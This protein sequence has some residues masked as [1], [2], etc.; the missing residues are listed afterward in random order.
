ML[1]I[2]GNT[3]L[4]QSRYISRL[5]YDL[6]TTS[7][8]HFFLYIRRVL[9]KGTTLLLPLTLPNA[10]QFSKFAGRLSSKFVSGKIIIK[11]PTQTGFYL[12]R[13]ATLPSEMF[14]LRSCR[15]SRLCEANCHSAIQNSCWKSI[16]PVMLEL[17]YS[18]MTRYLSWPHRKKKLQNDGL[19]APTITKNK[20]VATTPV[21]EINVQSLMASVGESHVVDITQVTSLILVDARVKISEAYYRNM[22]LLQ[23]FLP[24]IVFFRLQGSFSFFGSAPAHRAC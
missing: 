24:A 8:L 2:Y 12:K 22:M 23:Q 9:E 5:I 6:Y 10:D 19:Y 18:L 11:Y 7:Y 20:D 13:V 14:V 3:E 15:A 21:Y 4:I 16:H 1:I 17:F